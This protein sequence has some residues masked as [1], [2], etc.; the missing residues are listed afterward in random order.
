MRTIYQQKEEGEKQGCSSVPGVFPLGRSSSSYQAPE[1]S[2]AHHPASVGVG[3]VGHG[4]H[5][6][7]REN[8]IEAVARIVCY[9]G[10]DRDAHDQWRQEPVTGGHQP[11]LDVDGARGGLNVEVDVEWEHILR[12]VGFAFA[13]EVVKVVGMHWH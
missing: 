7:A 1:S 12:A 9:L 3:G 2:V 6:Q 5:E 4:E 13:F 8:V 11:V 10:F